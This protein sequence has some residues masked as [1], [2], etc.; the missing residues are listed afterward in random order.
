M[1]EANALGK[2]L[3]IGPQYMVTDT[4]KAIPAESYNTGTVEPQL[5]DGACLVDD[6]RPDGH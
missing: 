4:E 3:P 1:P 6:V 2:S 5:Y